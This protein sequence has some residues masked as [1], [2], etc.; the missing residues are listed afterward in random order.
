MHV[1]FAPA[2]PAGVVRDGKFTIYGETTRAPAT[3]LGETRAQQGRKPTALRLPLV[4]PPPICFFAT[5]C[6]ANTAPWYPEPP[7]PASCIVLGP[8]FG[9]IRSRF[10]RVT[11]YPSYLHSPRAFPGARVRDGNYLVVL[12]CCKVF[13]GTGAAFGQPRANT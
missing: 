10:A 4:I 8:Q 1:R 9:P 7:L 2:S 5:Y 13:E 3:G 12:R 6:W 11:K